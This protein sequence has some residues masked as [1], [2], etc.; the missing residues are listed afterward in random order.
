MKKTHPATCSL[1]PA[2][3]ALLHRI[4]F[5]IL[6][7]PVTCLLLLATCFLQPAFAQTPLKLRDTADK[8]SQVFA[9]VV[10]VSKYKYVRPLTYAD[11]DAELFRDY[12]KSP[13][14]GSVKNENIFCLLNEDAN[15]A[16]FWSKG[17]QWLKS[18][19]LRRGDRLFIYLAGHGDAIDEDQFFFLGYDCNP[20]GDKNNYLVSGAIQLFNLK[21]KIANET[22]RGVDVVFI[23]DAC[24][25]S[26]LPGGT[27][28]QNFLNS[29]VSEKSAGEMIMLAT[30]A[31][32]ESLEDASIGN[33]H[34][35]FTWY[36]VDG[37]TGLADSPDRPDKKISFGE[38]QDYVDKNVPSVA[39]NTFKRK[40]DPFFCCNENHDKVISSIDSGYLSR[41]LKLKKS[42]KRGPGNAFHGFFSGFTGPNT[43]DTI[44]VETYNRFY[45]AIKNNNLTGQSSAE[46][47]FAQLN[48]K[49][50]GNPYTLDAQSSLAVEFINNAQRK[51]D[52][53]L[54]CADENS[55]KEKQDNYEAGLLLERAINL[56]RED[57]ADFANSLLPRMY[58]L[59]SGGD[60]G[61]G[62]KN[63]TLADAFAFA[64]ANLGRESKGAYINNRMAQLF[65]E[66]K[67]Y[68]SA[69]YYADKATKL[70]PNWNCPFLTLN[71][72][73]LY[74]NQQPPQQN[75]VNNKPKRPA[76]KKVSFGVLAG[77]GVSQPVIT[78]S[79]WAQ[80]QPNYSDSLSSID[81]SNTV[82]LNLGIIADIKLGGTVSIRPSAVISMEGGEL[83]YNRKS[84][85]GPTFKEVI[86]TKTVSMQ[87]PLPFV[88]RFSSKRITPFL[89]AGPTFNLLLNQ[90]A[91]YKK[92]IPLKSFGL[93]GDGAFGVDI[94]L[95]KSHLVLS[96]QIR[97]TRGITDMKGTAD[98]LYSNTLAKIANQ[99]ITFT[100]TLRGQ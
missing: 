24:R 48:K 26:E 79:D 27:A 34:G 30:A 8:R 25:T 59:K 49:Y 35:L 38:I 15:N 80:R 11:K 43:A 96:P 70:A 94:G 33:G 64:R 40:Q 10:G 56:V 89:A 36:L 61:T 90:D 74:Q 6:C 23:M 58:F 5:T 73:R 93:L 82:T 95:L 17:F 66:A 54:G 42:Q 21:K 92:K 16:N 2:T 78:Y 37:L 28:G 22:A 98:N 4:S 62:G 7:K 46:D 41:W 83:T 91:D 65:I 55:A 52:R 76:G 20:M 1:P 88:F 47:Y 19:Q 97:Y 29:A 67:Q 13:G 9:M 84:L 77:G 44:L 31:G 3:C 72:A 69:V 81:P 53:Y 14:G 45:R 63:G 75:P 100:I 12:L 71:L 60:F 86:K 87:V 99:S 85:T 18:K 68:D 57:D 32:E 50:P 39:Q 51:I